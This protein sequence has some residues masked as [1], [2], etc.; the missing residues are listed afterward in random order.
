MNVTVSHPM[1]TIL[2]I[3][4]YIHVMKHPLFYI[5]FMN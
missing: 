5:Y 2:I 3:M 4:D 1:Q